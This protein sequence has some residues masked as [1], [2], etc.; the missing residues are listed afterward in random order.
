L[1][2][3]IDYVSVAAVPVQPDPINCSH[4]LFNASAH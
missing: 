2:T 3:G 1:R 4:K